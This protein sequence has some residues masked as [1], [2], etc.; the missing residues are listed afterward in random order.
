MGA[1][2]PSSEVDELTVSLLNI[3]EHR[4]LS[5]QLLEA[6]IQQEVDNTG[7]FTQAD[8][9]TSQSDILSL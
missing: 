4:G 9:S 5:F 8:C 7:L 6:L 1:I 3:F 2:C